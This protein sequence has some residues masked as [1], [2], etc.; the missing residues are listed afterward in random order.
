MDPMIAKGM[1]PNL[2]R[3][4]REGTWA[5]P[6]SVDEP[7]HLDPWVTWVTVHTGVTRDVHGATI[8]E[9]DAETIT[10][11]RT[12]DYAIE[13][14][15]SVGVFGSISAYPPRPVN[16]F[17]VPG[18]FAPGPETFPASLAPVQR[19]NRMHTQIHNKLAA[20][21]GVWDMAKDGIALMRDFGLAPATCLRI[22]AQLAEE[23][24]RKHVKWKRV[25]LQPLA[26]YD[27]FASLYRRYRPAYATW[28]TN[29]A[30]HYMHHYW[31]A[32]D[33]RAFPTPVVPAD[34]ERYGR[35]VE[36]GYRIADAL[37][38]R[39]LRLVDDDT[40]VVLAS[41]MGQ[42]PY[43]S[44]S[45][46]EGRILVSF[47]DFPRIL[48]ILGITGATDINAIMAPQWNF[49]IR[50]RAQRA[51]ACAALER[52][53]R[54]VGGD[55]QAALSVTETNDTITVNPKGL[56][57][58]VDGLR[59]YFPDAPG[60]RTEGY[61]FDEL[62]SINSP[63]AKQGMHH[64]IGSLII[65]GKGIAADRFI[66]DTTNLDL[67]PTLLT[68]LGIDVPDVMTGRVLSELWNGERLQMVCGQ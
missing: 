8:L 58:W 27:L 1:L 30:A 39:F 26:N 24:L 41:S 61:A 11:K 43:V 42:Q 9:Q 48:G 33:D 38:G 53:Q 13:A 55:R 16:G 62:F 17:M 56:A 44:E 12:W 35:A 67:A 50:D 59:Y 57:R 31:K 46:I 54:G 63:T 65:R 25:S 10:A 6:R 64:P 7:P 2:E 60:D 47:K 21:A 20:E 49:T 29:H 36:H 66:P 40:I 28:H 52:A 14:G 34:K 68:L 4:R 37:L 22:A 3:M 51:R 23:R 18:P 19:L 32:H 45:Y 5:S 15:K